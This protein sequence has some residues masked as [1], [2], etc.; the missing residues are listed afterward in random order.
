MAAYSEVE[1]IL[2]I[3]QNAPWSAGH[4]CPIHITEQVARGRLPWPI[5]ND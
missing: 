4:L 1:L 5:L 3:V 2:F